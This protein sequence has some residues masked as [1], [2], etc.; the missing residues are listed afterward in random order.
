MSTYRTVA[1]LVAVIAL[2][3]LIVS[4]WLLRQQLEDID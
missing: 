2:A 1:S 4:L 3:G